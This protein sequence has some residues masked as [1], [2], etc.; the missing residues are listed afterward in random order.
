MFMVND[1][2]MHIACE[3]NEVFMFSRFSTCSS[4]N[5]ILDPQPQISINSI[6]KKCNSH[7]TYGHQQIALLFATAYLCLLAL[8]YII[9]PSENLFNECYEET[10]ARDR[11]IIDFKHQPIHSDIT[12]FTTR[13]CLL[14]EGAKRTTASHSG[15]AN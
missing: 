11:S 5:I 14:D 9:F 10:T 7:S 1:Y 4:E 8:S 3:I 15:I 13:L 2:S 12:I 6:V